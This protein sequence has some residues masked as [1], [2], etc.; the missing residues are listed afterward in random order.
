MAY[1]PEQRG[2]QFFLGG[3]HPSGLTNLLLFLILLGVIIIILLLMWRWWWWHGIDVGGGKVI[4]TSGGGG[5]TINAACCPE[6]GRPE[7]PKPEWSCEDACKQRFPTDPR[8]AEQCIRQKCQ[9]EPSCEDKCKDR[10]PTDTAMAAECVRMECDGGD[11]CQRGCWTRY[12]TAGQQQYWE[13]V[14]RECEQPPVE[15]CEDYCKTVYGS[16][17]MENY[18]QQCLRER[19]EQQP[20]G[21][22]GYPKPPE[23]RDSDGYNLGTAGKVVFGDETYTDSC[24]STTEVTEWVCRDGKPYERREPCPGRCQYGACVETSQTSTAPTSPYKQTYTTA[25]RR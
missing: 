15:D 14:R 7:C 18:Y 22:V 25:L 24:Y 10:Y 1:N 9:Q 20:T 11:G 12:G 17:G 3:K 21:T 5:I 6:T 4:E 2:P 19:C 16:P 23:C 8:S 13:C